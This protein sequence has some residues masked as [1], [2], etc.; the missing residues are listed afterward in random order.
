MITKARYAV[1]TGPSAVSAIRYIPSVDIELDISPELAWLRHRVML[2]TRAGSHAYGTNIEGSDLDFR[3]IA[4]P[5]VSHFFGYQQAFEHFVSAKPD[6]VLYDIRKFFRLAAAGNPTALEMLFSDEGAYI[7]RHPVGVILTN[8][9]SLFLS[10]RVAQSFGGMARHH[11]ISMLQTEGTK[12][13]VASASRQKRIDDHGFDTK[14]AMH[15]VRLLRMAKEVLRGDGLQV[16]RPDA[17]ELL[18]IRNGQWP[19]QDVIGWIDGAQ[20]EIADLVKKT[21]LPE[22]PD[23]AKLQE[24][25][26]DLVQASFNFEVHMPA[27]GFQ[28]QPMSFGYGTLAE[29]KLN[30]GE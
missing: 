11:T 23:A 18:G 2:L 22:K 21:A 9:R 19:L 16:K 30:E 4:I 20:T 29:K 27:P 8:N 24:M 26:V 12:G 1:G 6:L 25:C 3:G 28:V 13:V 17:Q 14:E 15:I 5:P 7:I 10:R